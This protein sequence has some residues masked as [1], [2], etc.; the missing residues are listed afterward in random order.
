M[1]ER[2][3][4][5]ARTRAG[6]RRFRAGRAVAALLVLACG[7]T[8]APVPPPADE[9]RPLAEAVAAVEVAPAPGLDAAAVAV[10]EEHGAL[11]VLR[12]GTRDWLEH[13]GRLGAHGGLTVRV[14]VEELALRAP[15]VVWLFSALAGP[16]R[17]EVRVEALRGGE[18]VRT[19]RAAAA[20]ALAGYAWRDR[21]ERLR[22]LAR[23]VARRVAEGL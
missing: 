17:L 22:R 20:S 12:Q 14:E 11:T 1:P 18:P 19:F 6:A 8:S 3:R 9:R 13:R 16:D 23:R 7:G 21:G 5:P 2:P 15:A 4:D 10:L